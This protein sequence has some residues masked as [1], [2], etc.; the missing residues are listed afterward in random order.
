MYS[1][2]QPLAQALVAVPAATAFATFQ[3]AIAAVA[4]RL[5]SRSWPIGTRALPPRLQRSSV[6]TATAAGRR[7]HPPV[8]AS[9]FPGSSRSQ[10]RVAASMGDTLVCWDMDWSL[11]EE[12]SD[13]FVLQELGADALYK[14]GRAE[15]IQWTKVNRQ[16]AVAGVW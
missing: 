3:R 11:V 6:A 12:N 4:A 14:Q 7:F 9:L 13:T 2:Y 5:I 15:G 1:A 16:Q 8:C 10:S